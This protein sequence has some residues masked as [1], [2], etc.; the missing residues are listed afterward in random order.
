MGILMISA[1]EDTRLAIRTLTQGAWGY[2][3]KPIAKEELTFQIGR[4]IERRNFLIAA[5]EMTQRLK[6]TVRW[7]T[8]ML[9]ESHQETIERLI[10]ASMVR[11]DETGE[12][13]RRIG[14]LSAIVAETMGWSAS[15]V[16]SLRLAAP[17]HDIGKVGIPDSILRK[18]GPLSH[19][20]YEVMKT[21]TTIGAKILAHS[22]LPMIQ[23]AETIALCHHER[24]DGS[25]YPNGLSD[26]E[27]P[28]AARI[29]A[30]VDVYDALTHDRV[31]RSALPVDVAI[32]EIQRGA[33]SHFDPTIVEA[34]RECWPRFE[35][36]VEKFV[37][38][39]VGEPALSSPV[40]MSP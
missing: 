27:I 16:D 35:S 12:H 8:Q 15:E 33:A 23:M 9:R 2:L 6:E 31:Y 29:V 32:L 28:L 1:C 38:P 19:E 34:F 7:Q 40:P 25:G 5:K 20:E 26:V 22:N 13:I 14:I 39:E 3:I 10:S 18:P 36:E 24:W 17:M 11:D 21:H 37:T 30:V 4:M